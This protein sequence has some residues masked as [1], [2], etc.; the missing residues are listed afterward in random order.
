MAFDL[1]ALLT[2]G[3]ATTPQ[4]TDDGDG[5]GYAL[6]IDTQEFNVDGTGEDA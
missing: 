3:M 4:V 2:N 5:G 6:T 1:L